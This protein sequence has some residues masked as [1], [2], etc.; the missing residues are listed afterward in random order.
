MD[1][2]DFLLTTTIATLVAPEIAASGKAS[3]AVEELT[4]MD[5]AAGYASGHLT[6]RQPTE[7]YLAR[8]NALDR[9]GPTLRAVLETNASHRAEQCNADPDCAGSPDLRNRLRAEPLQ[10]GA[11]QR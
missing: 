10:S 6:S 5:I 3:V 7:I 9:R 11:S 1:R 2:R 8:I 4:L